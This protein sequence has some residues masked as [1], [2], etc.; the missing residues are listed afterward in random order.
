L[1]VVLLVEFLELVLKSIVGDGSADGV[2]VG[3]LVKVG[4]ILGVGVGVFVGVIDGVGV[5]LTTGVSPSSCAPPPVEIHEPPH[6]SSLVYSNLPL[7][8]V[9]ILFP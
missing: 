1:Y 2:G 3:L 7:I 5:G 6:Y 4:V 9:R 8:M